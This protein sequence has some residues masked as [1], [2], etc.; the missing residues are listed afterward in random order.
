MLGVNRGKAIVSGR[1][2]RMDTETIRLFREKMRQVQRELGWSQRNDIQCCGVTMAQCHALLEIGGRAEISIVELAGILG[3]DTSTLS[4]TVENMVKGG[5]VNRLLNSQDRRYVS[6]SLTAQGKAAFRTIESSFNTYLAK[7]FAFIPV[8][9][10]G[11]II[12]SLVGLAEAFK[13]CG[14]ALMSLP[15]TEGEAP[16]GFADGAPAKRVGGDASPVNCCTTD[17]GKGS[18]Q[19]GRQD[20]RK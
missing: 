3:V 15:L 10:H 17:D 11:Q 4:R 14:T 9:K 19:N 18:G 12:E 8:E 20:Q 2:K 6:L 16:C 7:V 13:R 1:K 5:L